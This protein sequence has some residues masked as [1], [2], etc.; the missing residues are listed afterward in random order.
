MEAARTKRPPH[1]VHGSSVQLR[2]ANRASKHFVNS[3]HS[4]TCTVSPQPFEAEGAAAMLSALELRHCVE[5]S[6]RPVSD[7][8]AMLPPL[9]RATHRGSGGPWSAS[10]ETRAL[11]LATT[12]GGAAQGSDFV[13]ASFAYGT[14][15]IISF[16]LRLVQNTAPTGCSINTWWCFC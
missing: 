2:E 8:P 11:Q 14:S 3:D 16:L 1:G 12:S 9:H 6:P 13:S 7:S 15:L 4:P 5:L 10:L